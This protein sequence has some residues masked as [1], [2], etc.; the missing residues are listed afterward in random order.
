MHPNIAPLLDAGISSDSQPYLALERVDG[1]PIT[2]W[3]RTQGAEIPERL[4]LFDQVCAAVSHAH[5]NLVVHRDIKPSNILVTPNGVAR[6]LDFGIAKLLDRPAAGTVDTRTGLRAFTLHYAAPEQLRGEPVTT[7]T[8]VYAMGM[9]L[10][11]L[12][13]DSR[14]Y[15][16][17]RQSDALW[18]DAILHHLSLIHI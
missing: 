3:C 8:D 7:M 17:P 9:V 15:A 6:L 13:S 16:L 4:R 2:D 1:Q 10:H 5:A 18:E 12:L 11:E 14:A